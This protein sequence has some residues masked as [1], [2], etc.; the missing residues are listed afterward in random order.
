MEII[1]TVGII[2]SIFAS[3][4]AWLNTEKIIRELS[5]IK[6]QLHIKDNKKPSFLDDDLDKN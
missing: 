1:F 6:H 2:I 3:I 5:T 4:A